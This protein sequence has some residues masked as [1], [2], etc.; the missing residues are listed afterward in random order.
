MPNTNTDNT[1]KGNIVPSNGSWNWDYAASQQDMSH[2]AVDGTYSYQWTWQSNSSSGGYMLDSLE[3]NGV[4]ITIPFYSKYQA[5]STTPA[6]HNRWYTETI[7]PDGAKLLVEHLM[8]FT[9]EAQHVYRF[10]VT[11]PVPT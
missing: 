6:T 5:N 3:V 9:N 7:L 1:K 10:T 11:V 4:G 2:N 8:I